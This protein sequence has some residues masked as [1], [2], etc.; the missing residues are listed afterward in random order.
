MQSTVKQQNV[1]KLVVPGEFCSFGTAGGRFDDAT[2]QKAVGG[3]DNNLRHITGH[4]TLA[5]IHSASVCQAQIKE[6]TA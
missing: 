1:M 4:K 2:S 3:R 6:D 5:A